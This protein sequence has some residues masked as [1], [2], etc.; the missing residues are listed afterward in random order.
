MAD[1]ILCTQDDAK[2][3]LS[4]DGFVSRLDDDLGQDAD[5]SESAIGDRWILRASS[6]V[7]VHLAPKYNTIDFS[8]SNPPTNTPQFVRHCAAVIFTYQLCGRRSLPISKLLRE[9]HERVLKMLGEIRDGFLQLPDVADSFNT[10]PFVSNVTVYGASP[11]AKIR[12]ISQISTGG[13]PPP[14]S[15]LKH[16]TAGGPFWQ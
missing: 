13:T 15:G 10:L 11:T 5:A 14:N 1:I 9:E 7:A 16:Y 12:V 8:G 2:D 3:W 6:I 4:T